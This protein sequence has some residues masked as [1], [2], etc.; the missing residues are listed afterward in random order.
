MHENL[1]HFSLVFIC[2]LLP[3]VLRSEYRTKRPGFK[4]FDCWIVSLV[5]AAI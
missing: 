1:A 2:F 3:C 5:I 4:S